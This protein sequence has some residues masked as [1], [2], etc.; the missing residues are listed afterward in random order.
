MSNN[1]PERL[2]SKLS[3]IELL[4]NRI[5]PSS[6]EHDKDSLRSHLK[7]FFAYLSE[8]V[9]NAEI[10]Q[11]INLIDLF[12][13]FSQKYDFDGV[14]DTGVYYTVYILYFKAYVLQKHWVLDQLSE[15]YSNMEEALAKY[16]NLESSSFLKSGSQSYTGQRQIVT[17][18]AIKKIACSVVYFET[19]MQHTALLSQ[20]GS[21]LRAKEKSERCYKAFTYLFRHL[22]SMFGAILMV[23]PGSLKPETGVSLKSEDIFRYVE[24]L[25]SFSIPPYSHIEGKWSSE[26]TQWKFN[27][28]YNDKFIIKTI[29]APIIGASLKRKIAKDWTSSFHISSVVKLSKFGD[30][31]RKLSAAVLDDDLVLRLILTFSCCIFSM[32]AEN[33]FIVKREILGD[34]Q[35][36]LLQRPTVAQEVKL[37][38]NTQYIYSEKVHLKA[39]ELLI[40][41]FE[42]DIKLATHFLNSYKKNYSFNVLVIDEENES[43]FSSAPNSEYYDRVIQN[44]DKGSMKV[45]Y[46]NKV[47]SK[48]TKT[49]KQDD[50]GRLEGNERFKQTPTASDD[51]TPGHVDALRPTTN[52][53]LS[54][55]YKNIN[56]QILNKTSF[57]KK[58]VNE[59]S[60]IRQQSSERKTALSSTRRSSKPSM[61]TSITSNKKVSIDKPISGLDKNDIKRKSQ[62]QTGLHHPKVQSWR[63]TSKNRLENVLKTEPELGSGAKGGNTHQSGGKGLKTGA[64]KTLHDIDPTKDTEKSHTDKL[65]SERKLNEHRYNYSGEKGFRF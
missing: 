48:S 14:L 44:S 64:W 32:A 65:G 6:A 54:G 11:V 21:N 29:E 59:N 4:S 34:D 37:Q 46:T 8:S 25:R 23:G 5:S 1:I 58:P 31:H 49:D 47:S 60:S 52:E 15:C 3:S 35:Q 26:F 43:C 36:A 7:D 17:R 33:R 24:Y 41:G 27:K 22:N 16:L 28:D 12:H 30:F 13:L 9:E 50:D 18:L 53:T 61:M 51:R 62:H 2:T 10:G 40:F 42:S 56:D 55:V 19:L 39:L 45:D 20:K 63:Q 57:S 38:K